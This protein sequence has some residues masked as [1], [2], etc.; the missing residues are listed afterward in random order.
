M[1]LLTFQSSCVDQMQT[2]Y[3]ILRTLYKTLFEKHY[4]ISS[5]S[6]FG[7]MV[8]PLFLKRRSSVFCDF[9]LKAALAFFGQILGTFLPFSAVSAFTTEQFSSTNIYQA[10]VFLQTMEMEGWEKWDSSLIKRR[11]FS[12]DS[13]PYSLTK[14]ILI[15]K[16][17]MSDTAL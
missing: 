6:I 2:V 1:I 4:W 10:R 11:S 5:E 12:V 8:W 15:S 7:M 17:H 13:H 14:T 16:H 9:Q 3:N